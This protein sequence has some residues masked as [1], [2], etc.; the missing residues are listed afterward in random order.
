MCLI[1]G[2]GLFQVTMWALPPVLSLHPLVLLQRFSKVVVHNQKSDIK[3]SGPSIN[4]M[5]SPLRA[6]ELEQELF[7]TE[8][9]NTKLSHQSFITTLPLFFEINIPNDLPL[10]Y[11][12]LIFIP[13]MCLSYLVSCISLERLSLL[14]SGRAI[15]CP[16]QPG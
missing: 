15:P 14:D 10:R 2:T 6:R 5:T 13:N 1:Q 11:Y 12:F 16:I 4:R 9:I 7:S 8:I 3:I